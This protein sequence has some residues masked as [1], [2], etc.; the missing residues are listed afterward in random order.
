MTTE[1]SRSPRT[2]VAGLSAMPDSLKSDR[3]VAE[4]ER[5]IL[6]GELEPGRRLPTEAEL[7]ELLAVSR[8]VVRDAIRSLAARGLVAVKQ[9]QGM[10][11]AVPDDTAFSHALVV[12]LARANLTMDEVMNARATLETSLVPLAA[13]RGTPKDWAEL[14]A[15]YETFAAAVEDGQFDVAQDTHLDFHLG[16]LR[17]I[18]QP[19]LELFLKPMTAV[20][21]ITA[22]PPR[23]NMREDWEVETHLPILEA[24]EAGDSA[25]VEEAM[26]AHFAATTDPRRYRKFRARR[27]TDCAAALLGG[28]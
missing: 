20:M 18:H 3:V 22:A 23:A 11:V 26:R 9:G 16:L 28:H 24:L 10:T 15:I 17:A 14:R 21:V 2:A 13:T 1:A 27:F 25:A 5:R 8:S 12:L 7:C 4:L 19:A 6:S